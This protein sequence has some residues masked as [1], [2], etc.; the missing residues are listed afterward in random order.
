MDKNTLVLVPR[1]PL[2]QWKEKGNKKTL[3]MPGTMAHIF[4]LST[5]VAE[6]GRSPC[7]GPARP[8]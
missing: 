7:S 1:Q 8:A 6:A 4:N 3:M 5:P 2:G